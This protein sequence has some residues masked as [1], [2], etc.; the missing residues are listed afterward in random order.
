MIVTEYFVYIHTS[1]HAGSF[2]NGLLL[3]HVPSA[4]LLRYHGQVRDLP[5]SFRHLPVIGFVR[6]PWDARE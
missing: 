5:V 3:D 4:K 2:I 1:R 6:N